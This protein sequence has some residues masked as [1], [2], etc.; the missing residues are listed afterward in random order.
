MRTAPVLA[1]VA[2][3]TLAG[4]SG[5]EP[6]AP[7]TVTQTVAADAPAETSGRAP[8]S[9]LDALEAADDDQNTT[10]ELIALFSDAL[11]AAGTLADGAEGTPA[12]DEAIET[13]NGAADDL[14]PLLDRLDTERAAY[15]E[16]ALEC[17][18]AR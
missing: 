7:V 3:L 8:Q 17:I 13:L 6:A 5:G 9:C 15:R 12:G 4:C 10:T 1:A 11:G 14:G 16:A 18:R 2:L